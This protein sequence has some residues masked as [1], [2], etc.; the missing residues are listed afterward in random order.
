MPGHLLRVLKAAAF[1]LALGAPATA[2]SLPSDSAAILAA[3]QGDW[4]GSGEARPNFRSDPTR[5]T[6]RISAE[7]DP[8]EI[9]LLNKGKCGTTQGTRNLQGKL[10]AKG[11]KLTGD[12]LGAAANAGLVNPSL[13]I[14]EDM[15][16]SEAQVEDAGKM[17]K[18]RTFITPPQDDAFLVQ[19]Q[20]LDRATNS[21]IVAGEIEF[22]RQ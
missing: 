2:Q 7:F 17:V 12:F 11:A 16:V 8:A 13:R 14:A 20:Y 3:Y 6:C 15:I 1:A 21:W 18:V 4:R 10:T 9:A 22:R 19:S 5:I